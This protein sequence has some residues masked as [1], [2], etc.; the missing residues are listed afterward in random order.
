MVKNRFVLVLASILFV[1]AVVLV[2]IH[3]IPGATQSI[4]VPT[5]GVTFVP[6]Y[7]TY[8][9]LDWKKVYMSLLDDLG[10]R[11]IRIEVPW[12]EI[13]PSPG[14]FDLSAVTW[15]LDEAQKRSAHVLVAVGRKLPRWP[16]CRIPQWVEPLTR[17]EQEVRTLS[18]VRSVVQELRDH[19][20]I[21]GW[22]VENEPLFWFGECPSP[23]KGFY[24][25]EVALVRS[26]D[27]RP[28]VGTDSGELSTWWR[29]S[30][31]VDILGVSM[32]HS[33]Y[34]PLIGYTRY[35]IVP[36]LYARKAWLV[37]GRV[38]R[39]FSSEVQ[40]EP[41]ARSDL[42]TLPIE[43]QFRSFSISDFDSNIEFARNTGFDTFYLWGVEWWA[44]MRDKHQHPEFWDAA[45]KLYKQ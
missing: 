42:L 1:F 31:I 33:T 23:D 41:W 3:T 37:S 39:I 28:I 25:Q 30:S 18:M 16:E 13:E 29:M 34:N 35:P 21:W 11:W 8:L 44:W 26:I 19:P 14:V 32:Y 4:A 27:S 2:G 5:W 12:N 38:A 45:K 10:V 15:Q 43:E 22:Q 7:A 20:A 24:E 40:M 17:E 6:S 36:A 9:G